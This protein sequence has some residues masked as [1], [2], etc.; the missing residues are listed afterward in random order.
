M[1]LR[2]LLP[3]TLPHVRVMTYGYN[4]KFRNFTGQQDV[5]DIATKLL[6]E[7]VDLRRSEEVCSG[8]LCSVLAPVS[9]ITYDNL[10]NTPS[11]GLR[12][13]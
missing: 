11:I 12:L 10:G 3:E 13:S 6:A 9:V 8:Q 7:V 4:A 5:R 2:D 1:W